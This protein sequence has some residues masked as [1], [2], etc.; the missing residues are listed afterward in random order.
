MHSSQPELLILSRYPFRQD[1]TPRNSYP[2]SLL[3]Q[4]LTPGPSKSWLLCGGLD[5]SGVSLGP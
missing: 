1:D 3:D 4:G 5:P 2:R